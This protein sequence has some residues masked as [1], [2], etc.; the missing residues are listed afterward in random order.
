MFALFIDIY[1]VS[2]LEFLNILAKADPEN[3]KHC[4]R[5]FSHFEHRGHLCLVFEPMLMN[6][7]QVCCI[8]SLDPSNGHPL[9][10]SDSFSR[11]TTTRAFRLP[12]CEATRSKC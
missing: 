12:L 3:K 5:L 1:F 10:F 8:C 6:L 4:I 7:R 2:E 11:S 9:Q